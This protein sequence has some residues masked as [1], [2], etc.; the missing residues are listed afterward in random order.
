MYWEQAPNV[1]NY[2]V[3]DILTRNRF[4]EIL[5]Y[6]HLA[7]NPKL[8]QGDKLVKVRPFYIMLYQRF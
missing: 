1:F 3:L 4:E 8:I 7:D 6:L 5:R 2:A